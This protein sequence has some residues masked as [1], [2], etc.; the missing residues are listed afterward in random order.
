[1]LLWLT[2]ALLTAVS[3]IVVLAPLL[4]ANSARSDAEHEADVAVY[5]QQ[6]AEIEAERERGVLGTAEA[7]AARIEVSRRLLAAA[8]RAEGLTGAKSDKAEAP[9]S[10]PAGA[11]RVFLAAV[12]A[13]PAL[14]LGLYAMQGK[15]GMPA[16]PVAE[17]RAP[18]TLEGTRLAEAIALVEAR[19]RQ[20]PEDGQGWDVI[21]PIY[22]R[23]GRYDDAVDAFSRAIRLLGET[24]KRLAG[25]AE[26]SILASNGIIGE[27]ARK[28]YEK[29]AKVDPAA[30]EP[31]FWL[32]MAKE[33]NG[34]LA[35]AAADYRKLLADAPA[36]APWRAMV[37]ERIAAVAARGGETGDRKP[38]GDGKSPDAIT[39]PERGPS[40][41]EVEAAEKM[42]PEQRA[43]MIEGMVAGLAERLKANNQDLPGWLRLVRAYAVLGRRDD[44]LSA[45]ASA[46]QAFPAD[47]KALSELARLARALGLET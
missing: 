39:P 37:E 18:P 45:L 26:A 42:P 4:K 30:I 47:E 21:A 33:Q 3:A 25:F 29:L 19:L 22:L 9:A 38:A 35:A 40:A 6:L 31:R 36:D 24:P 17:R 20:H 28:A 41:S 8:E 15:P 32:A 43:R 34:E 2:L 13:I 11:Q 14:A 1:M 46:R 16:Y 27:P 12:V 5:R 44:A 23:L 7:E 10:I